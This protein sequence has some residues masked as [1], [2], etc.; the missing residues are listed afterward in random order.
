MIRMV[1]AARKNDVPTTA[2]HFGALMQKCNGCHAQF[3]PLP[4]AR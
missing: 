2:K 4:P 1:K 3:R